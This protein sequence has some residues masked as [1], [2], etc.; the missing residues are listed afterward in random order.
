MIKGKRL[1][2]EENV[3]S[4][5]WRRKKNDRLRITKRKTTWR[6]FLEEN[7]FVYIITDI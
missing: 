3:N 5:F 2:S 1:K 6:Q 7:G 4:P